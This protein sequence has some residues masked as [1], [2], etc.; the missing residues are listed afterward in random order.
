MGLLATNEE[1]H[2]CRLSFNSNPKWRLFTTNT[3]DHFLFHMGLQPLHQNE[4]TDVKTKRGEGWQL[5]GA[6][7]N[8]F[9]KSRA[10]EKTIVFRE[11]KFVFYSVFCSLYFVFG[12]SC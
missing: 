11:L 2:D 7:E 4:S 10:I 9:Q 1:F 8:N 6:K 5:S 12:G 3:A